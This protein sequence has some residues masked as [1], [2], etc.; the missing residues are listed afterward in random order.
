MT[1][2]IY[3]ISKG[4]LNLYTYKSGTSNNEE[5]AEDYLYSSVIHGV[6]KAVKS[7]TNPRLNVNL[8][9]MGDLTLLF[10][11]GTHIWG[12]LISDEKQEDLSEKLALLVSNFET[13]YSA[14]LQHW[15]GNRDIFAGTKDLI[16]DVFSESTLKSK[17]KVER[18]LVKW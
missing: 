9:D 3:L 17:E 10:S 15:N 4:G 14:Y 7:I 5:Q 11:Y 12:F 16:E 18:E 1:L 2:K 13:K 8:I 6:V